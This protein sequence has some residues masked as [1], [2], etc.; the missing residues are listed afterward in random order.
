MNSGTREGRFYSQLPGDGGDYYI[1]SLL[2][3]VS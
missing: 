2:S 1:A 3:D